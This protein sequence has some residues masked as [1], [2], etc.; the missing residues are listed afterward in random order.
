MVVEIPPTTQRAP[1]SSP[2][3]QRAPAK[4]RILETANVLFYEDG[5]RNV[6]VDRIISASSVTKATF[7]KHYRAKD[8]LIVEYITARH[9]SVRANV[10]AIIAAAPDAGSALREFV[11]AVIAEIDTPGFRGCPFINAAAE[12]PDA[13]HPVRRVVTTHREW[14]VDTLAELL[15]QMGHPVPGDAAD[16][17]LLARDGALSGGYAGDSIAASAALGRIAERVLA[18]ARS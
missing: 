7:Y 18:E 4:G 10:E 17:L 5:I 12:F 3:P 9:E 15:K 8:N 13:D 16:E 2:E 1:G 11:A 6:G 14:Y